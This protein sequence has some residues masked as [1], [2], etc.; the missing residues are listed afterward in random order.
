MTTSEY[1]EQSDLTR[2]AQTL[3]SLFQK[4][5]F[6]HKSLTLHDREALARGEQ[7]A[8]RSGTEQQPVITLTMQAGTLKQSADNTASLK[9]VYNTIQW[10][11][12][13]D[14][15]LPPRMHEHAAKNVETFANAAA[16]AQSA[17]GVKERKH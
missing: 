15:S 4:T 11:L 12:T 5:F 8:V 7:V 14:A 9:G 2:D 1:P 17:Y 13:I 6:T 10:T 16:A 3:T